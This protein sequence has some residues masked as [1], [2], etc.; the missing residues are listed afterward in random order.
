MSAD[1]EFQN[2]YSGEEIN[3]RMS[4]WKDKASS[5]ADTYVEW[6]FE[7]KCKQLSDGFKI[8]TEWRKR[9]LQYKAIM[10]T[11]VM[12]FQ[13]YSRH[14]VTPSICILESIEQLLGKQRVDLLSVGD[15]WLLLEAAYSHDI[16]LSMTYEQIVALWELDE[17]FQQ[18]IRTCIEEDLGDV[19]KAALYYKEMDN[20]LH[21]R[22]KMEDLD[23]KEEFSFTRDWPITSQYY[24]HILI[25]EYIRKY[26]AER[27]DDV[28][29]EMDKETD[30][31]IP[32]RLYRVVILVSQMHG[33]EFEDIFKD[34]KY[35][36]NGFGSGV[37]HPQFVA[38][39]LRMGD[40]LDIDN[41]R[42]DPYALRHFGR[43]PFAS[44]LHR[45]KHAA[46]THICVSESEIAV[47]ADTEEYEVAI[48]TDEWFRM[49]RREVNS[50]ICA[51]NEIVPEALKG[52]TLKK[53]NCRVFFKHRRF[54]SD[55]KKEFSINKKKII[56]LLIGANIYNDP[57][58]FIRE[59]LQN[60]MD[61]S[62]MQLW[63]DLKSGKYEF[64]RNRKV[65]N[66]SKINP[67]DLDSSVYNN[68]P[69]SILIQWDS[70]RKRVRVQIID[71]GIG[72]EKGYFGQLSNI[73]T[74]WKGR[75]Y[76]SEELQHM[77]DWLKPTGGFGIG[78][79]SAFM[80]TDTVEMIT[81]S[82]RDVL[83]Y[84]VHLV[85]PNAGGNITIEDYSG[86]YQ[87]GTSI[88]FEL[89][90]EKFQGWMERQE[91]QN[92]KKFRLISE[93]RD[94]TYDLSTWDEFD[95]DG[96]LLY[97]LNSQISGLITGISVRINHRFST[98]GQASS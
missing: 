66:Y 77:A 59:Y 71:R 83:G 29:R 65:L 32:I 68:Y 6:M 85:S 42:F 48:L 87:H 92:E 69:I 33:R 39:M 52:C 91:R 22:N 16:G 12:D 74:G 34:L 11:I 41:N 95:S 67:F 27:V 38:A 30:T 3:D 9:K 78:I 1:R 81:K 37:L 8:I 5:P 96:I 75:E 62:K 72:I 2:L 60:A 18:F 35:R 20:L 82:D 94:Y 25:A 47:E 88:I 61:A 57:L 15:L 14:D 43:L 44:M 98:W 76:Y 79:Q 56:N 90:P 64:Q 4:G 40:L 53:S 46:I 24:I 49:I 7:S 50:L 28:F 70:D 51:W 23:G 73:G 26:H 55:M 80:V 63:L 84:R 13:H 36:A 31:I 45:K 58:D 97:T 17:K 54:D 19:S 86:L 89:E 93:E 21:N 10:K